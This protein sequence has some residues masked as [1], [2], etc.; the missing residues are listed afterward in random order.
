M[1]QVRACP[2]P[3][4]GRLGLQFAK[5]STL[6]TALL[7][8]NP[9]RMISGSLQLRH[10]LHA[11][12]DLEPKCLLRL[13]ATRQLRPDF[14][15]AGSS[16]RG[17]PFGAAGCAGGRWVHGVA[18]PQASWLRHVWKGECGAVRAWCGKRGSVGVGKWGRVGKGATWGKVTPRQTDGMSLRRWGGPAG[19]GS[20]LLCWPQGIGVLRKVLAVTPM[21]M[22]TSYIY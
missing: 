2:T 7:A 12:P 19:V 20:Q 13:L 21:G 4:V 17:A 10:R 16:G 5:G 9:A 8:C 6:L 3:N 22:I 18:E 11:S 15:A 14:R 1:L